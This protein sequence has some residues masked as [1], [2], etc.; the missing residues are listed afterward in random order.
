[1]LQ[2]DRHDT[3]VASGQSWADATS[4]MSPNRHSGIL[5]QAEQVNRLHAELDLAVRNR[6]KDPERWH[7][8][9]EAFK[10]ALHEFYAPFERASDSLRDSDDELETAVQF[11]EADPRC[12]RSGYLKAKLL[13]RVAKWPARSRYQARLED[14]VMLRLSKPE[15]ASSAPPRGSLQTC[16]TRGSRGEWRRFVAP[17]HRRSVRPL[18]DC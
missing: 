9:A 4:D 5:H 3:S 10:I 1:M 15:Q 6:D 17:G 12:H 16:G 8:A 14:V 11:L 2:A 18:N 7:R 13:Q